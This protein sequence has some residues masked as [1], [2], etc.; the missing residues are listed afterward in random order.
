MQKLHERSA[1]G[2]SV[3][4]IISWM[5]HVHRQY[6]QTRCT[7]SSHPLVVMVE[8]SQDR[9][10]DHLIPCMMRGL[11]QSARFRKLLPNTLMRSYPVE[12]H[13]IPIEHALELLLAEDQ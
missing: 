9:N 2:I 7:D 13:Y 11:S 8:S 6:Y 5:H 3:H 4:D 10:S 1:Q 12:V